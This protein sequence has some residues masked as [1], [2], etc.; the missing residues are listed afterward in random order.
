MNSTSRFASILAAVLLGTGGSQA[1]AA[2]PCTDRY[3]K[4][5]IP[6]PAGSV[7]DVVGRIVGTK[8]TEVLG[9]PVVFEN[10]PGA[11]TTIGNAAVAAS[12][13]DGCTILEFTISGLVAG[14]MRNDLPYSTERDLEPVIG[15]GT[16]PLVLAVSAGS[17]IR[18][19]EDFVA[20]A[21]APA[22][23]NYSTG[24]PGT[25]AHLTSVRLLK[26]LGGTG[27]HVPFKGNAYAIQSLAA[28]DVQFMFPTTADALPLVQAGKIRILGVTSDK[29]L[30]L[31]P[32]VPTMKELGQADFTPS[33]WYMFMVPSATPK[34]TITRLYDAYAK[35]LND[36]AINK[37]LVGLGYAPET[38]TPADAKAYL[39]QEAAKWKKVVEENHIT[40][41]E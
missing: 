20:A 33:V 8:V 6:Q 7:G 4:M 11:T 13:P 10:R 3:M 28:N 31:I 39:K 32:D 19:Y 36:P 2:N 27:T 15:I 21:K 29:R 9:Q 12:K 25:V 23:L 30:P 35:A 41:Y 26:E 17:K 5:V 16:F 38:R 22:G 34:E 1:I 18:T 14:L 37:Q 24:G 40:N